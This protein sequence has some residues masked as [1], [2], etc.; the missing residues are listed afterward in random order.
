VDAVRASVAIPTVLTPKKIG[1]R[2]L[3]DGGVLNPLPIA[4]TV[5][6]GTDITISVNLGANVLKEYTVPM[7]AK[8]REKTS[9]MEEIFF[10]MSQKAE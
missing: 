7:P 3:L 8:V 1:E 2:Y 4:P 6:D 9:G 10:E 5:A